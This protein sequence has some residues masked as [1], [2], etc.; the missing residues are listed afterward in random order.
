MLASLFIRRGLSLA[1]TIGGLMFA[2]AMPV[3]AAASVEDGQINVCDMVVGKAPAGQPSPVVS[4]T[5]YR[6][7]DASARKL[8]ADEVLLMEWYRNAN[9]EPPDITRVYA[10][11]GPCDSSGYRITVDAD[12]QNSISG[13]DTFDEYCDQVTGY[14]NTDETGDSQ[15]WDGRSNPCQ[16]VVV[17][18]VG[19]RMNDRINSWR[20]WQ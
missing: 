16:C 8:A 13:F 6:T 19:D 18:Y 17:G 20:V 1:V 10:D 14:A 7:T 9:N 3:G 2:S 11:D 15:Y 4:K 12:W 5:C